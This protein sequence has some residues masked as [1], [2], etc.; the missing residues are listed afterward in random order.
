MP[1]LL[2]ARYAQPFITGDIVT[3]DGL[4]DRDGTIVFATSHAYDAGIMEVVG[5]QRDGH[6]YSLRDI[7][8]LPTH[9]AAVDA[10]LVPQLWS[11]TTPEFA[12]R[13]AALSQ[14]I[15]RR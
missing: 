7:P 8:E 10:G 13:I 6:Y 5:Q 9:A 15:G 12:A 3:Y 14:R 11:A 1:E 4:L 2:P